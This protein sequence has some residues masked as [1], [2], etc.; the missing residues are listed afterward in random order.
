MAAVYLNSENVQSEDYAKAL[1]IKSFGLALIF[2]FFYVVLLITFVVKA[3]RN[4]TYVLWIIAF[5]CQGWSILQA[6]LRLG[7]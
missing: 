3:V 4:P 1:L 5:F 6:C 2:T 7:N